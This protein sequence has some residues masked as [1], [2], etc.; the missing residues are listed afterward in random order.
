MYRWPWLHALI[1]AALPYRLA[2][3]IP[4]IY[5]ENHM[6]VRSR[7][8]RRDKLR[9]PDY[10]SLMV[11]DENIPSEDFLV[12]QANH[13]IIGGFDPDT[14]LFTSAVYYLLTNPKKLEKLQQE[15]RGRFSSY[16]DIVGDSVQNLAWMNAVIEESL[17]LHTNGAFGL[18]RIS[19]GDTVDGHYI[20]KGASLVIF[21]GT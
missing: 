15:V 20:P 8:Q 5:R 9:H 1:F 2:L 10:F 17:R 11:T 13:L 3:V 4:T 19:P 12:A 14:N 18:P 6:M 21:Y 7:V 16:D